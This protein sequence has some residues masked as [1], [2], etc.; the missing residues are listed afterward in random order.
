MR[1]AQDQR[2]IKFINK[3]LRGKV[4]LGNCNWGE[5]QFICFLHQYHA[6]MDDLLAAG[7]QEFAESIN[8]QIVKQ[9]PRYPINATGQNPQEDGIIGVD[10]ETSEPLELKEL[11]KENEKLRKIIKDS[12][13][14]FTAAVSKFG[15]S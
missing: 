12:A 10:S 1:D 15:P 13:S 3:H 11:R 9:W 7:Q 14:R 5:L 4:E 2:P 8:L 6:L